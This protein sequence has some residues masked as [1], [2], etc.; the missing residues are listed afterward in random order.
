MTNFEHQ[1]WKC[2]K[3]SDLSLHNNFILCVSGGLDSMVLLE[4]FAKIKSQSKLQV[5]HYHHGPCE[6][7][8]LQKFRDENLK[9]IK[10]RVDQ[11]KLVNISFH[12]RKSE[13]KLITEEQMREA[14]WD[15]IKSFKKSDEVIV[16]AHHLDDR[17]E[18]ILLKM[19]RGTGVDGFVSFKDWNQEIFRPFLNFSKS[20][21]KD[22]AQKQN[23]NWNRDPSNKDELYLR[24]WIREKWLKQ[25]DEKVHSG[26]KNLAKSFFKIADLIE[27]SPTF[28]LVFEGKSNELALS[29]G[30]Y[31]S[32]S[33][34]EQLRALSL[35]LKKHQIFDFTTG[36][37]EEIR[38]RLDKNQK[39]ITFSLLARKW[40][41]NASQIMLQ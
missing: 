14:R 16:T 2:F 17:F 25:L 11:L 40:V 30:W 34:A 36:Q 22:F 4:V 31:V 13:K 23:I 7:L 15:F 35:Y 21:L 27:N 19:I 10:S 8:E 1:V 39:D 33:K 3:D 18:T 24:N 28:E 20:E 29:R 38:K 26:S 41:I 37:L 12:S 32:L 6:D 9:L 5:L